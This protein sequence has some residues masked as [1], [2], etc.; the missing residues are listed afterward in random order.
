MSGAAP[1][2]RSFVETCAICGEDDVWSESFYRNLSAGVGEI[3][4]HSTHAR[5]CRERAAAEWH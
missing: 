4:W 5:E 3:Y 1:E 2:L